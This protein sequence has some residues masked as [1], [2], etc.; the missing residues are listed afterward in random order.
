MGHFSE[1][2]LIFGLVALAS[3]CAVPQGEAAPS[4][5]SPFASPTRFV[6]D[7]DREMTILGAG[8]SLQIVSPRGVEVVLPPSPPGQQSRFQ[9]PPY[10]LVVD[11]AEALW[12][13]NG[14]SPIAC[15][16]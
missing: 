1:T 2:C 4:E 10:S 14:K 15:K 13:V 11:D 12:M 9:E 3:G 6:C 5:A 16:R 7:A 8:E